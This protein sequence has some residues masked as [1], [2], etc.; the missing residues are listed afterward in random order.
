MD[1]YTTVTERS[2]WDRFQNA[3]KGLIFAP[4]F[5]YFGFHML[6]SGERRHAATTI[7]LKDIFQTVVPE[8]SATDGDLVHLSGKLRS[9]DK[10][11]IDSLTGLDIKAIK[12]YRKVYTWQW[13]E[14]T[15]ERTTRTITGGERTETVYEYHTRWVSNFSFENPKSIEV[16]YEPRFGKF[17]YPTGHENPASRP[18]DSKFF[19]Q[20]EITLDRYILDESLKQTV[21]NF[22]LLPLSLTAFPTRENIVLDTLSRAECPWEEIYAPLRGKEDTDGGSGAIGGSER[23]TTS[24]LF[25]GTGT[26]AAPMIGD[27]RIE[28]WYIPDAI[29]SA[30]AQKKNM[31]LSSL[32]NDS[33]FIRSDLPCGGTLHRHNQQFAILFAGEKNIVEMFRTTHKEN[34]ILF[35]VLRFGGLLFVVGGF[36]LFGN[37]LRVILGWIPFLGA[38]WEKM[39]F[40]IMQTLGTLVAVGISIFY[41]LKYNRISNLTV[42]DFYFAVAI[43]LF[44]I[45]VNDIRVGVR[46][47][48]REV[49]SENF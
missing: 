2:W 13:V 45:L 30:V 19:S 22:E 42:Y 36:L 38:I 16:N 7:A 12:L 37:P 25:L 41:F 35:V 33:L 3:I 11:L 48:G 39:I 20:E 31:Q 6:E 10:W 32:L 1:S 26:P 28:Y 18:Y 14:T 46:S 47:G 8:E 17:K 5:F 21:L 34:D 15:R 43:I 27:I 29:Y 9:T 49:F 24:S 44:L 23:F 40:K 4:L